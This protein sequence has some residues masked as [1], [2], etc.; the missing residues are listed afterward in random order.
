MAQ[1]VGGVLDIVRKPVE[2]AR[3]GGLQGFAVGI[4]QGVAGAV[5]K[6]VIGASA[7]ASGVGTQHSAHESD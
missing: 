6:P 5:V 7:T 4:G 2:G 1:G 3:N